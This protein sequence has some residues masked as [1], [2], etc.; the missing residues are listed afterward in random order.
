MDVNVKSVL[1]SMQYK[2]EIML[3]QGGGVIVNN[4]SIAGLIG[5]VTALFMLQANMP[6]LN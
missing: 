4:A 5:V 2:I 3:K 6:S 1:L